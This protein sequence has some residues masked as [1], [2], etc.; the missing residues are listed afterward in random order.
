VRNGRIPQA[1]THHC[2]TGKFTAL[3]NGVSNL[4]CLAQTHPYPATLVTHHHESAKIKASSAFDDLRR[5]VD[6]HYFLAQ[7]L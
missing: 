7:F 6:E 5:A 4:T 3:A 1:H 2:L